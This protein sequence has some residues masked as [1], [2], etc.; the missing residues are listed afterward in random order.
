MSAYRE[1]DGTCT[2]G[3]EAAAADA[4]EEVTGEMNSPAGRA[5]LPRPR[6]GFI[7]ARQLVGGFQDL[8]V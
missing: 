6:I 3:T 2:V 1:C 5:L 4:G 7:A 8:L